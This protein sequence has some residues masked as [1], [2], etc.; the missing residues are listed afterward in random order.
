MALQTAQNLNFKNK[1]IR[2]I[3]AGFPGIGKTTLAESAPAPL[4]IDLDDGLDRVE[5]AYRLDRLVV[6]S[7][8]EL[9]SD[10]KGDLSKYQTLI[11]DTGGRLFEFIKPAVIR[12]DPKNG[13]RD[14]S[15]SLAGYGAAARKFGDF[16]KLCHSLDK[17]LVIIF[18]AKEEKDSDATRLRIMI[19][20]QMKDVI[21]QDMDL[22]GFVE[23]VG[24]K[25][26]I[27]FNNCERY[28]AKGTHGIKGVY[29]I[30]EL[31]PGMTNDFLIKLFDT[32][33]KNL[34]GSVKV[35]EEEQKVYDEAMSLLPFIDAVNSIEQVNQFMARVG[36]LTHA[37]T[38]ERELKFALHN[39]A[40]EMGLRYDKQAQA[41]V[42]NNTVSAQ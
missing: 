34:I 17:H 27:G 8:D 4:L 6:G 42:I 12:D 37:L 32:Y 11:I 25:R 3:I 2:M 7:Y 1:K 28:Y 22:G 18:H 23:I 29:E 33:M 30:P 26:T 41:Y 24:K 14:N 40:K 36:Q 35:D 15:L 20:G 13:K 10:L 9:L 39:K 5:P 16:V 31:Q 19:E 21:W 38:S